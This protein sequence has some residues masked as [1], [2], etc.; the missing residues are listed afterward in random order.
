MTETARTPAGESVDPDE[1]DEQLARPAGR[2]VSAVTGPAHR[3]A[4]LAAELLAQRLEHGEPA[5]LAA[6]Q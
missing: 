5:A 2:V 6:V 4:G 3:V 1:L